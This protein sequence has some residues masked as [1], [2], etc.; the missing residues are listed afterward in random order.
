MTP[1][2]LPVPHKQQEE[3]ADCLAACAAMLFAYHQIR[4]RYKRLYKLLGVKWHGTPFSN[5]TRL[6]QLGM[7]VY[8]DRHNLNA[9]QQQLSARNPLIVPVQ[10][11]ELPHFDEPTN[12]AVVIVGIDPA[13]IY[14]NDPSLE[15]GAFP[16]PKGD[17]DLAWLEKS[18]RYAILT[19]H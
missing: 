8:L 5:L 18:E 1:I 16:V 2:L 15:K 4:V 6:S 14:I 10:A 9:I 19:P 12:H 3:E 7:D 17:F 13:Y 11:G